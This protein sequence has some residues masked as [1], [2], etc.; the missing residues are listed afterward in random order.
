MCVCKCVRVHTVSFFSEKPDSHGFNTSVMRAGCVCVCECV[1]DNTRWQTK[2]RAWR[3][4]MIC[5]T[6]DLTS[7][8]VEADQ[9]DSALIGEHCL[10]CCILPIFDHGKSHMR[11]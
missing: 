1:C 11:S 7:M 2:A 5:L 3:R 4:V 8:C 9:E 6:S 10:G